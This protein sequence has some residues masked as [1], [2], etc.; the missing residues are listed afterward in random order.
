MIETQTPPI[1]DS[2]EVLIVGG[3]PVGLAL[4]G[5]LGARGVTSLVTEQ[6]DGTVVQPKMDMVG[7]RT[8]EFCRRWGLLDAVR[9][10]PY[11]LDYR[12]EYIWGQSLTGY[13]FDRERFAARGVEKNAPGSPQKRE[14]VPQNMFDPILFDFARKQKG[15]TIRH[16]ARLVSFE[17]RGGKVHVEIEDLHNGGTKTVAAN[18]LVG[19]DGGGSTVRAQLGV[20][21]SGDP[22]LTYTT[23]IIFKSP[24]LKTLHDKGEFYRLIAFDETGMWGTIVVIDGR[25]HYRVSIVGTNEPRRYSD[26]EIGAAIRKIVGCDFEFEIVSVMPWIRRLMVADSYRKGRVFLCGDAVHMF[27]PTGGFGMNTGLQDS[28]DLAWKLEAALK[29]WAGPH[30]LDSYEIE[31]RPVGI[32]NIT[33]AGENLGRMTKPKAPPEVFQPGPAGDAAR[34]KFGRSYTNAMRREWFT[35]GIHL[36]YRYEHS[37]IIVPD[38]TPPTPDD[39]AIYVETTRPGHRAPHVWL[40]TDGTSTLDLFDKTFVLMRLGDDAPDA[41]AFLASARGR[42]LPVTLFESSQPD[43]LHV[44]EK[45]L[46]LVRPDGHVAWRG[47]A[48]P[49]DLIDLIDTVRG[50]QAGRRYPACG[51]RLRPAQRL[52]SRTHPPRANPPGSDPRKRDPPHARRHRRKPAQRSRSRRLLRQRS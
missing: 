48:F 27:S 42:N 28:V 21:L 7:V 2:V 49:P 1:P 30:L 3:G 44:Y 40:N 45:K 5:D 24:V 9:D 14:R 6:S 35:T 33:E 23:N 26:E 25:D 34:K 8:I 32:R 39:P 38:G 37:P 22:A 46:V 50:L 10:A 51:S 41:E 52:Y 12:Q 29:G 15:V 20:T 17:E 16:L 43:L 13:E 47:D 11:P 31:R 4:A 18:Y 19:C 36:G